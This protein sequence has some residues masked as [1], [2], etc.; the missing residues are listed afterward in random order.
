MNRLSALLVVSF[1]VAVPASAGTVLCDFYNSGSQSPATPADFAADG[2][3]GLTGSETVAAIDA[4]Q[5]S[6]HDGAP[7]GTTEV[8]A[9]TGLE[10][11][12]LTVYPSQEDGA[13]IQRFDFGRAGVYHYGIIGHA[14]STND[15]LTTFEFSG[16]SSMLAPN[17]ETTL[18]LFT[19]TLYATSAADVFWDY[20]SAGESTTQTG[21]KV[22]THSFTFTTSASPA[23]V[24]TL[25]TT[26]NGYGGYAGFA[27]VQVPEPTT[28]ALM[29]IG[30]CGDAPASA[31]RS[32]GGG[33]RRPTS[34][35]SRR[36]GP[37]RSEDNRE[38]TGV[39]R[40]TC[41]TCGAAFEVPDEA[42]GRR[43]KCKRCGAVITVPAPA[44]R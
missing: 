13:G 32:V 34:R 3:V 23:D 10:G 37:V 15:Y 22:E 41:S 2:V 11:L 8:V 27:L 19:S 1:L 14:G 28:M 36:T 40:F 29:G 16:L 5:V 18:Y 30:A 7:S 17:T 26:G 44:R 21:N 20:G 43:G 12:T 42:A 33:T 9:S 24:L 35:S 38:E 31:S 39:V 6:I 25:H 4:S